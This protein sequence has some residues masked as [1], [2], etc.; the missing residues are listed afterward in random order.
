[1]FIGTIGV[2]YESAISDYA[3]SQEVVEKEQPSTSK[4]PF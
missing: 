3:G 2:V 4:E 1:M